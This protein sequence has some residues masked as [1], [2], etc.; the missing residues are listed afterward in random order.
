MIVLNLIFLEAQFKCDLK[1]KFVKIPVYWYADGG[2][3]VFAIPILFNNNYA[4]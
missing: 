1:K 3:P 4:L 2:I